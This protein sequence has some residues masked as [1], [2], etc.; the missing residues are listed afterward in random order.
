MCIAPIR[1]EDLCFAIRGAAAGP[2]ESLAVGRENRQTIEALGVGHAHGFF[3][4]GAVDHVEL[5]VAIAVLVGGKD[6]V[7]ARG[8]IVGRPRHGAQMGDLALIGTVDIHGPDFGLRPLGIEAAPYQSLSV[9]A[10]ERSTVIAGLLRKPPDVSAIRIH[11]VNFH[12]V[13]LV[14]LEDFLFLVRQGPLV[15]LPV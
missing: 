8:V 14:A 6:D 9:G 7:V 4:A 13:G 1:D 3:F 15:G 10:E 2:G 11:D 5:E 12:E